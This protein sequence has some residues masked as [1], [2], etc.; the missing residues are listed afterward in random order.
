[1]KQRFATILGL[2]LSLCLVF[3][4]ASTL[5]NYNSVEGFFNIVVQLLLWNIFVFYA[6]YSFLER[7]N[8]TSVKI[9]LQYL[10]AWGAWNWVIK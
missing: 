9:V 3:L 6:S 5:S 8:N 10:E 7:K 4:S 2:A 1:M